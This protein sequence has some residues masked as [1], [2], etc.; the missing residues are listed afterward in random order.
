MVVHW[1]T[2]SSLMA[3]KSVVVMVQDFFSELALPNK[4]A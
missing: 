4:F 2:G 1:G 3:L